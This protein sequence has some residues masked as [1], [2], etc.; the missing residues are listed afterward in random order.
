[1]IDHI[2]HSKGKLLIVKH[3]FSN[4][5]ERIMSL[6][7]EDQ[8]FQ[9]IQIEN[10][11]NIGN[12]YIGKIKNITESA[13]GCFVEINNK[14]LCYLSINDL[15]KNDINPVL[16]REWNGKIQVGDELL[17]QVVKE[18][19]KTKLPSVSTHITFTGKYVVLSLGSKHLG[20]SN[21]IK[22]YEKDNL[23]NFLKANN[24]ISEDSICRNLES[25][26]SSYGFILRTNA[27]G[28]NDFSL[29]TDEINKFES[30]IAS[31]LTK[32]KSRSCFSC[33]YQDYPS[34]IKAIR[35]IYDDLYDEVITDQSEVYENLLNF[36]K[37]ENI[38]LPIRFY[39]DEYISLEKLYSI[40]SSLENALKRRI[41]LK[42]GGYIIIE[43]TEALISIDV[44]SGKFEG[45]KRKR[46]D[47]ALAVNLEAAKEIAHQL[48]LRNLSGIII[49][50]F[51]SMQ[52]NQDDD[53]LMNYLQK[54]CK[55][56]ST[57]T[58]VIDMTK[59]GLV[60]ITRKKINKSL[61]EQINSILGA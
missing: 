15:N 60:E 19:I 14:E 48:K 41:W 25:I 13:G 31:I 6:L 47:V 61:Q 16:N 42:S 30:K 34:Y 44:N 10:N 38:S 27:A 59:L 56:D 52:N 26:S 53:Q 5:Q 24:Y 21:K 29:L 28:L 43:Q 36:S 35:D 22:K 51:I 55:K 57:L 54:L 50:D 18:A 58:E 37:A 8:R 39:S 1:M 20:I 9:R 23:L 12:V 40:P 7:Y 11:S 3:P 49:V 4:S 17:V 32:A 46:N 45:N 2:N 33:L